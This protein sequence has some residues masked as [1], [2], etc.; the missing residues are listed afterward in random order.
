MQKNEMELRK[1]LAVSVHDAL[2]GASTLQTTTDTL[3]TDPHAPVV[4]DTCIDQ[5]M[6]VLRGKLL[7]IDTRVSFGDG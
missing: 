2:A 1:Q 5:N 6:K 4:W 3:P 7:R